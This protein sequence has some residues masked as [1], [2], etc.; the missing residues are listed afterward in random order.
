MLT[1]STSLRAA[2]SNPAV[3]TFRLYE[4]EFADPNSIGGFTSPIRLT[5]WSADITWNGNVYTS[6]PIKCGE[7]SQN[8]D[9]QINDVSVA[10]GNLDSERMIQNLIENYEVINHTV[11]IRQFF[12]D[13]SNAIIDDPITRTFTVAGAKATMGVVTFSLSIGLDI[14]RQTVPNRVIIAQFCR[15]KQ[16]KDTNCKYAGSDTTCGRAWR[17]CLLKG[18]TLNFGGFPAIINARLYF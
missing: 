10:V 17:D 11:T 4:L 12:K 1:L 15:W 16:F 5:D 13:T 6:W 3:Q 14:F 18:N 2:L 8:S 9:G 7:F